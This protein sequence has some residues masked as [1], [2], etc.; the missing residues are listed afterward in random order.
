LAK[1]TRKSSA[2]MSQFAHPDEIRGTRGFFF[3]N[4]REHASCITADMQ[5]LLVLLLVVHG[6]IHLFG[7]I[8]GFELAPVPQLELPIGR[9]AGFLWLIAALAW[10]VSAV[11]VVIGPR[12]WWWV[13]AAPALLLSQVMIVTAWGDAKF[14][15]LLNIALLLPLLSSIADS[16]DSSF[17][18]IYQQEVERG[19]ARSSPTNAVTEDDLAP[20]PRLVQTYLR[21]VGVV[22]KPRIRHLRARWTG[23]MRPRTDAAWMRIAVEQ[24]SFFDEF[25]RLFMIEATRYGVPFTAFHRYVGLHATMQVRVLSLFDVVDAKG[26]LMDQSETVTLF[27]D[28]CLL[29]P[30]NL[31]DADVIWREID[32]HTVRGTFSNAGHTI[33]A[34]LLFD[35]HG[36]LVNFV[37]EDR[38]LSADGKTYEKYPW[39]TPVRDYRD[40]NGRRVAV[41]GDAVWTK[42]EGDFTY[43]RFEL[44]EIAYDEGERAETPQAR[45][46]HADRGP[47]TVR[48]FS[49][50]RVI[51]GLLA[52]AKTLA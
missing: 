16:R 5:V 12:H 39:S 52:W 25:A 24:H 18:S 8:K 34:D 15:T 32:E 17:R 19:E 48:G 31:V 26:P 11:L 14:G 35:A 1:T 40:F 21:R 36:D 13:V 49:W 45:A 29:A 51:S 27:N 47:A 37:S 42:P 6:A 7:F 2:Q 20:L 9:A 28:L 10:L 3:A 44:R 43:A 41:H 22:G 23:E 30:A 33:S 46:S 38:Y 4:M 50:H